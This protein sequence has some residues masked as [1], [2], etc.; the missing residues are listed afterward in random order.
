LS[1]YVGEESS[2][3]KDSTLK[4]ETTLAHG[5]GPFIAFGKS[6]EKIH[7]ILVTNLGEGTMSVT[8]LE[9]IKM[10]AGRATVWT[11]SDIGGTQNLE[12]LSGVIL[13]WREV[14]MLWKVSLE[15]SDGAMP[16]DCYSPDAIKGIGSP[17]GSCAS[18]AYSQFGS[19][20]NGGQACKLSRQLFFLRPENLLP[21]VVSL[22]VMSIKP[23][24]VYF[25]LLARKG[26]AVYS[27]ITKIGL[28]TTK[29]GQSREYPRATFT[30][31]AL[32]P[33]EQATHAAAYATMLKSFLDT[34]P[35]T[36]VANG[37][38]GGEVL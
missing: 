12:E 36:P 35:A 21:D 31:G 26:L 14:R 1:R 15:Q 7:E 38:K 27:L 20:P 6:V 22:S 5:A 37:G 11:V 16:P 29:N 25:K 2:I 23:N 17:G 34:A 18:C 4:E 30:A 3:V 32:L 13:A 10:P 9:R 8:D 19:D 24:R 28:E 33:P